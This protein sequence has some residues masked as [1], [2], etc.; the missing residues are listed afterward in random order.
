MMF[1]RCC[2]FVIPSDRIRLRFS[3]RLE[4]VFLVAC[5]RPSSQ[6]LERLMRG[7]VLAKQGGGSSVDRQAIGGAR[8]AD[9]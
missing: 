7:Y 5:V 8:P 6:L 9:H 2:T 3:S 1:L 4:F